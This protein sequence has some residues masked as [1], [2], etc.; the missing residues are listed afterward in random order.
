MKAVLY[1]ICFVLRY[2]TVYEYYRIKL[3]VD[4]V[5]NPRKALDSVS[6]EKYI[7]CPVGLASGNAG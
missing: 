4:F 5:L 6:T 1:L 3:L 2:C 7:I